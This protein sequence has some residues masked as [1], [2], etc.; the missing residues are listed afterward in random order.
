M[1]PWK[2]EKEALSIVFNMLCIVVAGFECMTTSTSS[3][4]IYARLNLADAWPPSVIHVQ[5][6][7]YMNGA[8]TIW[9]DIS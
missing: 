1:V 5:K 4:A 7:R 8:R 9:S 6:W 2:Q 3:F